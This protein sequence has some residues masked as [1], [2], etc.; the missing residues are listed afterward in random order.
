MGL[1]TLRYIHLGGSNGGALRPLC[2]R[3]EC[4]WYY[5]AQLAL[6]IPSEF[7]GLGNTQVGQSEG[8]LSRRRWLA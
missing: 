6:R 3:F 8:K 7:V 2:K 5:K 1:I 4:P